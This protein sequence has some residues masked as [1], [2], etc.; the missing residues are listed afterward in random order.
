M[1]DPC[2]ICIEENYTATIQR[3]SDSV[4]PMFLGIAAGLQAYMES[5]G[6]TAFMEKAEQAIKLSETITSNDVKDFYFYYVTRSV[7]A[8]LGAPSY[9]DKY[10]L[11][12]GAIQTCQQGG[13]LNLNLVCP[14]SA[15][16]DE[17]QAED[18]LLKHADA[19]FSSVTTAGAPFPFWSKGDGTGYLFE[20]NSPVGGSG[21]EMSAQLES[22]ATYI[23]TTALTNASTAPTSDAWISQVEKNPL[24][25]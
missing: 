16:V 23:V 15:S 13:A 9:V 3:L 24:Y 10:G 11:V 21:V 18:A 12:G 5:T 6:D 20:G 17:T 19:P 22:I 2:R 14:E 8:N 25:A 4:G 1:N 7:Y